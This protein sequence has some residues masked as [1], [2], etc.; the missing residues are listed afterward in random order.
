MSSGKCEA[1]LLSLVASLWLLNNM[2]ESIC[3]TADTRQEIQSHYFTDKLGYC[4]S[5]AAGKESAGL[6]E[7]FVYSA[8]FVFIFILHFNVFLYVI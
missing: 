1:F 8:I 6:Y 7:L 4:S 3:I 2:L 5:T